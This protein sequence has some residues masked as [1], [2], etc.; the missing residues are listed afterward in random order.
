[1]YHGVEEGEE[2][3]IKGIDNLFNRVIAENLPILK[4]K[5]VTQVQEAYRTLN[6]QDQK[7]NTHRH[8]KIKT[9]STQNKESVLKATKEKRQVTY[10][11]NPIKITADFS[12]Q[13]LNA[14]RSWKDIIQALKENN[15]QPRLV[16]SAKLSFLIEGETNLPQQGKAKGIC[17]HQASTTEDTERTFTYR[18][19]N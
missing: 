17:N 3:Q 4:K 19:R 12:T 5:R 6:H 14:K 13:T 11:G 10:K 9:F 2:T 1:M 7:R 8:I 16:Y 15:C 18:K